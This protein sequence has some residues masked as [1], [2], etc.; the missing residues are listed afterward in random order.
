MKQE[1]L[2]QLAF[3]KSGNSGYF[4]EF[5][6]DTPKITNAIKASSYSPDM[7]A[8]YLVARKMQE[9]QTIELTAAAHCEVTRLTKPELI[10]A[11]MIIQQWDMAM[12]MKDDLLSVQAFN[13][14]LGK[15]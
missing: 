6:G 5:A 11:N 14:V 3:I 15:K 9:T 10:N 13:H 8:S 7:F 4:G 12:E 2:A 1:Q